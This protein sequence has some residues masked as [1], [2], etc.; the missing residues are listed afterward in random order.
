[1]F[2]AAAAAA[3]GGGVF[4]RCARDAEIPGVAVG[5]PSTGQPQPD[6]PRHQLSIKRRLARWNANW[7]AGMPPAL[8]LWRSLRIWTAPQGHSFYH[9]RNL[10]STRHI[11]ALVWLYSNRFWLWSPGEAVWRRCNMTC[12]KLLDGKCI[13][14]YIN[15]FRLGGWRYSLCYR[16]FHKYL[17]NT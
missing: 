7:D 5:G 12:L 10:S 1:M 17:V 3:A 16:G 14:N 4:D 11:S 15:P 6:A 9:F 2:A 8:S 13:Y